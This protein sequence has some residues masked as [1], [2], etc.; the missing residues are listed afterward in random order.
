MTVASDQMEINDSPNSAVPI[1]AG[2][3]MGAATLGL[4][5][6]PGTESDL[7]SHAIRSA[8]ML[9]PAVA[10]AMTLP[11]GPRVSSGHSGRSP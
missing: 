8:M 2:A 4:V 9:I 5:D 1:W 7:R 11:D 3:V 10:V 6:V